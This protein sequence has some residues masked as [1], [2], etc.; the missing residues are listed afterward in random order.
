MVIMNIYI[1]IATS[2]IILSIA[3]LGGLCP[4]LM[5]NTSQTK[6]WL[7]FGESFSGG[8]FLG[9]GLIHLLPEAQHSFTET[10]L[11]PYPWAFLISGISIVLLRLIEE[12]TVKLLNREDE[13]DHT[14]L[15][16]LLIVLLSIHAILAGVALGVETTIS[17]LMIIFFA[18][19]AHKGAE[20]FALGVKIRNSSLIQTSMIKLM[21]VFSLMTP[22]GILS[23][24]LVS[25]M[26]NS[27]KGLL[28]EAI[29]NS[30]AAGTF[31]YIASFHSVEIHCL[32][33]DN[34]YVS[35]T[36]RL[37]NFALGLMLMAI[38]AIWL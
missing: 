13:N 10:S 7:I 33:C 1:K 14:Y 11:S 15:A 18:I 23:G 17:A 26:L 2:L 4:I 24:T 28:A 6:K 21:I 8:I 31:I 29:F 25:S 36:M 3:L 12:G 9:A 34:A 35:T 30:I 16:F 27:N 37:F 32:H 22:L 38:V 20:A 5:K 19:I